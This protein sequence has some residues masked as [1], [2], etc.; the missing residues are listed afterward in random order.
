MNW[1]D[2]IWAAAEFET[3]WN[4]DGLRYKLYTI[5]REA[6]D[7]DSDELDAHMIHGLNDGAVRWVDVTI[8]RAYGR[9]EREDREFVEDLLTH[10]NIPGKAR[11][12]LES[13]L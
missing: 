4:H 9:F 1:E 10:K 3:E 5:P 2:D 13:Y 6:L 12:I 8:D 11:E 7:E